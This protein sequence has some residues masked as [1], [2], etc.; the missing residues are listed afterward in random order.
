[1]SLDTAFAGGLPE[2]AAKWLRGHLGQYEVVRSCRTGSQRTGVWQLRSHSGEHYFKLNRRRVRWGTELYVYKNWANALAPYVPQLQGVLDQDGLNGLL[3]SSL[4]GTP[5]REARLPEGQS[6]TAYAKAGELCARLHALARNS[7]YGAMDE[8]G[9]AV[10]NAGAYL[11]QPL[12]NPVTCYRMWISESMKAGEAAHAIDA[13]EARIVRNVIDSLERIDFPPPIPTSFDYTPGNW[14]VDDSGDFRGL[15]DFEN[16]V[17]GLAA[18]PFARLLLDYFPRSRK[19]ED[20]FY[21]GYGSRP[22]EESRDQVRIGCILYALF[23]KTQA[24]QKGS[25]SDAER[26]KRA[27]EFCAD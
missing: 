13:T 2:A 11:E 24:S 12:V 1:M 25:A 5:L 21:S 3:I 15:I 4:G 20:A 17:W 26:A 6:S 10:D 19:V 22:P 27:F 18:D 16:M 8:H 7:W 23:Y 14:I 9:R